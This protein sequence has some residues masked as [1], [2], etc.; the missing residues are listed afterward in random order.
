V[1]ITYTKGYKPQTYLEIY[2]QLLSQGQVNYSSPNAV[3]TYD[4]LK[5]YVNGVINRE[6]QVSP[7]TLK[8]NGEFKLQ[9]APTTSDIKFYG[10]RT[11]N[12][13]FNYAQV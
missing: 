10:V 6:I 1:L 5:V 4:V 7:E 11:Y 12:F 13:P 3:S 9:I 8:R 2:N